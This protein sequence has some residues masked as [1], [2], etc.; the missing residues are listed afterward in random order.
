MSDHTQKLPLGHS[1]R[2]LVDCCAAVAGTGRARPPQAAIVAMT[3]PAI[4][5]V[6]VVMLVL[7]LGRARV[8]DGVTNFFG[9]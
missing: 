4:V 3:V 5:R 8:T 2:A 6:Y 7:R 9:L 1:D